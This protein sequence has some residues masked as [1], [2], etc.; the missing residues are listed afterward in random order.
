MSWFD[1]SGGAH[2]IASHLTPE[3][4]LAFNEALNRH[5]LPSMLDCLTQD[6]IFENTSPAPDGSRYVGREAVPAFWQEFFDTSAG[7]HIEPQE[8]FACRD[9]WV[10]RWRDEWRGLDGTPGPVRGVDVYRLRGG[11]MPRSSP[12]SKA[13]AIPSRKCP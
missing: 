9:Q 10:M 2:E 13:E 4:V 11:L 7:A 8:V 5:D 12:T 1:I 3:A 6:T